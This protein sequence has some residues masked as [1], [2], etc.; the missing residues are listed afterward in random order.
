[1]T[2]IMADSMSTSLPVAEQLARL[3]RL[4]QAGQASP[5][6]ARTVDKLLAHEIAESRIQ[7]TQ[8]Q[9][10]LAELEAQYAMSSV[11]FYKRYRSGQTD[12]RM[13]FVEWAA[14]VQMTENL[15]KRLA[16]LMGERT[17]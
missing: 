10:D 15:Q 5:L 14:L 16:L 6:V 8:L 12:D 13:D 1:M 17:A 3:V 9:S 2:M 4:E 7:L 11:D